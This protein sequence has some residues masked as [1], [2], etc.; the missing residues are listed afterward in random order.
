MKLNYVEK[1]YRLYEAQKDQIDKK[2][3]RLS[4]YFD[5]DVKGSVNIERYK[6]EISVEVTIKLQGVVFRAEKSSD[7]VLTATDQTVE[8][9][10]SQI[11]KHKTKLKKRYQK[12]ESIRFEAF[13]DNEGKEDLETDEPRIVRVKKIGIKPMSPEEAVL[14]MEMVGHDFFVFKDATSFETNIVYKRKNGDYG[15]ITPEDGE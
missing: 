3:Q 1:N 12:N 11:R 2:L 7:D 8:S 13:S 14:Q 4:K 10:I 9:L 6:N 15:L 5:E